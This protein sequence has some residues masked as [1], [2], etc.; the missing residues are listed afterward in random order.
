MRYSALSPRFYLTQQQRRKTIDNTDLS[1]IVKRS[2][3]LNMRGYKSMKK[4]REILG[5]NEEIELWKRYN[6]LLE[7][8]DNND[9]FVIKLYNYLFCIYFR[10]INF[11]ATKAYRNIPKYSSV[12]WSDVIMSCICGHV[13]SFRKYDPHK[14]TLY[15]TFARDRIYYSVIDFIRQFQD[16][17]NHISQLRREL[18]PKLQILSHE[19][20]RPINDDDIYDLILSGEFCENYLYPDLFKLIKIQT[21]NETNSHIS[22]VNDSF[23]SSMLNNKIITVNDETELKKEINYSKL[24]EVIDNED[25]RFTILTTFFWGMPLSDVAKILEVSTATAHGLKVRGIKILRGNFSSR[26]EM[27]EYIDENCRCDT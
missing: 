22:G 4:T 8:R 6:K 13:E 14:G 17:P 11:L 10:N 20:K 12:S 21:F 27:M 1:S 3:V 7:T 15:F 26:S 9:A 18:I 24:L 2:S 5:V 19:L 25:I 23:I 16:V